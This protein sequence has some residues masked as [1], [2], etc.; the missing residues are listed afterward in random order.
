MPSLIFKNVSIIPF[1]SCSDSW[2][3]LICSICSLKRM[4]VTS[5]FYYWPSSSINWPLLSDFLSYESTSSMVA[6]SSVKPGTT[7]FSVLRWFVY[8]YCF[9]ILVVFRA[10]KLGVV[11][12]DWFSDRLPGW[13]SGLSISANDITSNF[14]WH[15]F[16]SRRRKTLVYSCITLCKSDITSWCWAENRA[17]TR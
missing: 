15:I 13:P 7:I 3:S 11:K 9:L 4:N 10:A 5:R 16:I 6:W 2:I 14:I 12:I 17:L 8:Y 1:G